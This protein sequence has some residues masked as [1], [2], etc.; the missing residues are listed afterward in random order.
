M[1]SCGLLVALG[2]LTVASCGLLVVSP[3]LVVTSSG[4]LVAPDGTL[5]RLGGLLVGACR[6]ER[7][8]E[9]GSSGQRWITS[10]RLLSSRTRL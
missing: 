3:V 5:V 4:L 6:G 1:A 9:G 2:G 10:R 7:G 8:G